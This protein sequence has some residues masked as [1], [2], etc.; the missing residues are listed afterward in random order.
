MVLTNLYLKNRLNKHKNNTNIYVSAYIK[1]KYKFIINALYFNISDFINPS[2]SI[3][4]L[5]Y[6][7]FER[8]LICVTSIPPSI[9][10]QPKYPLLLILSPSK[11]APPIAPNT[12][13]ILNMIAA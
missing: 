1:T 3:S 12:D 11:T 5:L 2:V 13:S 4:I 7:C 9:R 6:V 8:N 10:I